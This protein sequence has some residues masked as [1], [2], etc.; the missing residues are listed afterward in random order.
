MDIL[1][2]LFRI[3]VEYLFIQAGALFFRMFGI[4]MVATDSIKPMR[5][6]NGRRVVQEWAALI[7]GL[8]VWLIGG[9]IIVALLR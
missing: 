7:V 4:G 3:L 6:Q 8:F 1:L 5:Q 9:T 2:S